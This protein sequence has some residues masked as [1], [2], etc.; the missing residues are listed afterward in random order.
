[1]LN[2]KAHLSSDPLDPAVRTNRWNEGEEYMRN[3]SNKGMNISGKNSK[4]KKCHEY[5]F[6]AS[7]ASRQDSE[8]VTVCARVYATEYMGSTMSTDTLREPSVQ[9]CLCSQIIISSFSYK[10][11]HMSC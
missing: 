7:T 5:Y 9:N 6:T 10:K 3:R 4:Q 8:Q 11:L 2:V 1:M